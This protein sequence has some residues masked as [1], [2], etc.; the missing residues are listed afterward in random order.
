MVLGKSITVKDKGQLQS[1]I[2]SPLR[3]K[4]AQDNKIE[5]TDEELDTFALA[6]VKKQQQSQINWE[7]KR[8]ELMAEL[9]SNTLSE[10]DRKEKEAY[11]A[12][13][14]TSLNTARENAKDQTRSVFRQIGL[15]WVKRWKVNKALYA[16][17]GG[18]VIFQ[19]AGAEPIDAY[20][21]FL[22]EQESKGAFQILNKQYEAGL[23]RY[24]TDDTMHRFYPK[25]EG[26]KFINTPWW[27]ME[28]PPEE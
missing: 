6:L 20:R 9:K 12:T 1:Q 24:F 5:P 13:I 28:T 7:E 17:Y 3:E 18:R 21:D 22:K 14:E 8:G 26:A 4:F 2:F 27:T 19:Q 23:W 11:L 25:D 15:K 10:R 16:K